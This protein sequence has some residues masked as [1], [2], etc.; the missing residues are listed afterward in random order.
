MRLQVMEMG[1]DVVVM[2]RTFQLAFASEGGGEDVV[3]VVRSFRLANA[4]EGGGGGCRDRFD[5][6]ACV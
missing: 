3:V 6:L 1:G 2:V 5:P 4:S